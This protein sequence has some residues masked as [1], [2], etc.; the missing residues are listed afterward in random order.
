MT[1]KISKTR[2]SRASLVV[3]S[4]M[5][6]VVP[7]ALADEPLVPFSATFSG[8]AYFL[9]EAK[10]MFQGVGEATHLGLTANA[11]DLTLFW[12]DENGCIPNINIETLTAANGDQLVLR[13]DDIA[14]PVA[15]GIFQGTGEWEVVAG[16]GRFANATGTGTVVGGANFNVSMFE[17]TMTGQIAY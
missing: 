5:I 17:I 6:G 8:S 1:H 10:V 3:T 4:C 2:V 15:P 12:P 16:T 11:G 9:S 13:M 14:C 7:G